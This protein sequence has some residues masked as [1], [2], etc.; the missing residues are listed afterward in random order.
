MR[1]SVDVEVNDDGGCLLTGRVGIALAGQR[2]SGVGDNGAAGGILLGGPLPSPPPSPIAPSPPCKNGRAQLE[3]E[4]QARMVQ[5]RL[6][7]GR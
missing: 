3:T 2:V 6:N 7:T 5:V 4:T 1:N